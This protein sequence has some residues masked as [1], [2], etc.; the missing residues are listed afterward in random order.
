MKISRISSRENDTV[1]Y[2]PSAARSTREASPTVSVATRLLWPAVVG[3]R[4]STATIAACAKSSNRRRM[5][6]VS[7]FAFRH[8]AACVAIERTRGTRSS[9]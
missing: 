8:T 2:G 6:A 4:C 3:S 7:W 9:G 1:A 5:D